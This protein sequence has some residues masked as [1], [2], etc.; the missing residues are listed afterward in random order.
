MGRV[1]AEIVLGLLQAH[2]IEAAMSTDDAGGQ[3]PMTVGHMGAVRILVA[4]EDAERAAEVIRE[5]SE[6]EN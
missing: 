2:R 4:P 3:Y 5:S 1:Q 6:I